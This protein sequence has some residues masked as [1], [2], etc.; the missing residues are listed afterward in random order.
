MTPG[1]STAEELLLQR[2]YRWERQRAEHI[3]LT[4]PFGG[5]KV[6]DW[7]W[8]QAIDEVRRVAAYLQ[9]Q[10][11]EP[12]A[13]VAILSKNCAWWILADLAIWMA[14]YV[15]VPI[16]PSVRPQSVRQIL[17]RS[18]CKACF[19][20][21]TDETEMVRCGIPEGV[22]CV[23]FPTAPNTQQP[24]WDAVIA[25][26]AP[27]PGCPARPADDLATIIY[28]SGTTG[29]PK[30]VMHSFAAF[31]FNVK[32]LTQ[33]L[34]LTAEERFF[35]YLPLAHVVERVG[36]AASAVYLGAR[37][38][39]MEAVN[40]M[41]GD[42]HRAR[43]TIFLS[44]PRILLKFQ[45]GAF[46]KVSPEN[47]DRLMHLPLISGYVKARILQELGLDSVLHAAC[48]AAALPPELLLWYRHLGLEL[49]EGYGMTETLIT[50]FPGNGT[51]RP[52]FVGCAI[53][54]VET[55]LDENNELLV[56]SPMLMLG[57]HQD[58]DGTKSGFTEDGF[59]RTGDLAHIDPDGQ[60][61][62]IGRVKEQFKTSKGNYVAPAPI[63]SKLIVHSALEACCVMG[64]GL[65]NP[66]AVVV[67]TDAARKGSASP[68]ARK[69]LE[70][71][72]RAWMEEVNRELDPYERLSFLA[73]A[74]GPWTIRNGFMTP[75]LKLNRSAIEDRYQT[76]LAD[77]E[78][79]NQPVVWETA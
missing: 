67:L 62:I 18:A 77:W 63:E 74:E 58:P 65:A 20:G 37:I 53:P 9:S 66:S 21:A 40:T 78:K 5:G 36:I 73:I 13:R 70:E 61:K 56:R 54:G 38:F 68:Q 71:S 25:A 55:K 7:T 60:L 49:A 46:E 10:H 16:Y 35:S 14:G 22:L 39:F 64:C 23:C 69:A 32:S 57:Y 47:L 27:L 41:L 26:N 30:G 48:G 31:S 42:L 11:W 44:V 75:T 24:A 6:R 59:F 19:L 29:V 4:Q 17:E 72:L 33:L 8:A 79:Q 12:G 45:R 1:L 76:L 3:F 51:V 15:S 2:M 28:T 43:P 34:G 50:H 52:G